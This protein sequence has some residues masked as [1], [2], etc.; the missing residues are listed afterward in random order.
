MNAVDAAV[1]E[2]RELSAI[3]AMIDPKETTALADEIISA[4]KI[5]VGGAGRTFLSMKTFAMRLMQ[6]GFECYLVGEVC[7]PSIKPGDLLLVASHS[8][9]TAVTLEVV[10]KAKSHGARTA[11]LTAFAGAPIP[12]V[13]DCVVALPCSFDSSDDDPALAF[14]KLHTPG[15]IPE[16]AI[17]LILDGVIIELMNRNGITGKILTANHANLE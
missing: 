4:K 12:S 11:V 5:F 1:A 15:N 9:T 17:I 16:T 7:T 13:C 8:G 10:R 3:L 14:S 2:A 6:I